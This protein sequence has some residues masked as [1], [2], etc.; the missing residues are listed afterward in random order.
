MKKK[1]Y[2]VGYGKPPRHSRFKPGQSGNPKG[3]P[4]GA[5]GFD[6]ELA[7]EL[8]QTVTIK[9]NGVV[10][11]ISKSRAMVKSLINKAA[12]GDHKSCQL[13]LSRSD[14]VR[15]QAGSEQGDL[16]EVDKLILQD[17]LRRQNE[18]K[19]DDPST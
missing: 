10:R 15:A 11:K 3:R 12:M 8:K 1:S 7:E 6:A 5:R 9:E 19:D 18:R 16:A 4:K 2:T 13:V 14:L 17:Y